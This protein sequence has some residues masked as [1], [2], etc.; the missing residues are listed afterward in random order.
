MKRAS[1]AAAI[2]SAF[3]T[4]AACSDSN[5][6]A[7]V[8]Q[9][10][11]SEPDAT[12][13]APTPDAAVEDAAPA[14]RDVVAYAIRRIHLGEADTTGKFDSTA[15]KAFG[16]D[17]D[18][19]TSTSVAN[20][21]CLPVPGSA[22]SARTDGNAGN[23]NAWGR[24]VLPILNPFLPTPSKD[25]SDAIEAG[26]P[27]IV[28]IVRSSAAGPVAGAY[29]LADKTLLPSWD[30]TDVRQYAEEWTDGKDPSAKFAS[31]TVTDGVFDSGEL[32]GTT[33][34]GLPSFTGGSMSIPMTKFRIRMTISADGNTAS[35]GMMS[36]VFSTKGVQDA[37][38]AMMAAASPDLCSGSTRD[39]I[40]DAIEQGS[41]ILA[42][43]TQDPAKECNGISFGIAFDAV[44]VKI[45]TAVAPKEAP[46]PDPC[47]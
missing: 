33:L 19:I 41:D 39:S 10:P 47:K 16:R 45:A 2:V 3:V 22:Q 38:G 27:T 37:L 26:A 40:L 25:A 8:T 9:P 1:L 29:A 36:G 32:A 21:E 46:G 43:G 24:N 35:A 44:R 34:L 31:A 17:I 11:V 42:D 23:D 15:W 18:G 20:G 12:A 13:P 28:I 6:A 7:P 30:G 5:E 14:E 4:A